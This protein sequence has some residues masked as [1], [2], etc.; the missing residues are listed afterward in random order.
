MTLATAFRLVATAMVA[1][2][3]ADLLRTGPPPLLAPLTALLIVQVTAYQ[4]VTSSIQRIASVTVG[5]LLAVLIAGPLGFHWWTLGLVI[6]LAL[7]VGRMFRLGD[8]TLEVPIS[9]MLILGLPTES[10]ALGRVVETLIGAGVGLASTLLTAPVKVKPAEDALRG[11]AMDMGQFLED[12]A[13]DL[14]LEPDH[15]HTTRW[16]GQAARLSEK[17][18]DVAA[19]LGEADDSTRLNPRALRI[20][21]PSAPLRTAMSTLEAATIKIRGLARCMADRTYL[22]LRDG[23]GL[24]SDMW[25][26][27][28]RG[29]LSL[30]LRTLSRALPLYAAT[31]TAPSAESGRRLGQTTHELLVEARQHRE[32]LGRLLRDD[33]GHWPLHG[34]LLVHID[35][36][37]DGL[38]PSELG[39]RPVLY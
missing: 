28:V 30:T 6:A 5:V 33:P 14:H 4:T 1:Y 36:L 12:L 8:H 9:A 39:F 15:A 35:R 22:H 2:L 27:D 10:A 34:E 26:T 32:R 25:A 23:S 21:G 38:A 37:L 31:A 20:G 13:D 3:V 11:L 7:L 16:Q 19:R 29:E 17:A 24:G 18:R